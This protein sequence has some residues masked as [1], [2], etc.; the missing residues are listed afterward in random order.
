MLLCLGGLGLAQK[1]TAGATDTGS[2][3]QLSIQIDKANLRPN[4]TAVL[5]VALKNVGEPPVTIFEYL[6]WGLSASFISY[7]RDSNGQV[8]MPFR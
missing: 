6:E 2:G 8:I 1:R 4:D 7:F 3:L 5:T